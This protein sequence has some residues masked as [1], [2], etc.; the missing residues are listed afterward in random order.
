[1][2]ITSGSSEVRLI[3]VELGKELARLLSPH[4][5]WIRWLRF[6]PDDGRLAVAVD[7]RTVLLWDLRHIRRN[8]RP[9]GL[10]WDGPSFPPPL[11]GAG[12]APARV[13]VIG[14]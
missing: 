5:E 11:A 7:A 14:E 8:L 10:D 13:R 6:S 9:M 3:E 12:E 4:D 2:A 1:M